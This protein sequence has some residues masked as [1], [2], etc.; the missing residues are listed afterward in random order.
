[1]PESDPGHA[2]PAIGDITGCPP[3]IAADTFAPF[4]GILLAPVTDA[5]N[6]IP[7]CSLNGIPEYFVGCFWIFAFAITPVNLDIIV[8]PFGVGHNILFFVAFA[9]RI[10]S[11]GF[12]PAVSVK[13]NLQA[14]AMDIISQGFHV[15]EFLV[16]ANFTGFRIA[17][18]MPAVVNIYVGPA[19]I[20]K[21]FVDHGSGTLADIFIGDRTAPAV[22]AIPA[23]L[24][25]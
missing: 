1:L 4:P 8:T 13:A 5:E 2:A 7:R 24:G 9:A 6:D 19:I 10:A 15:R 20:D 16:G 21:T 22:P 18:A 23:H 11:T 14:E 3:R 12:R 25:S 17:F